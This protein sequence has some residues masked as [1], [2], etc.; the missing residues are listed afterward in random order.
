MWLTVIF[1]C[2]EV[3]VH[4]MFWCWQLSCVVVR[5]CRRGRCCFEHLITT[6]R[7]VE[8]LSVSSGVSAMPFDALE[9][10]LLPCLTQFWPRSDLHCSTLINKQSFIRSSAN[11]MCTSLLLRWFVCVCLFLFIFFML[12]L[13]ILYKSGNLDLNDCEGWMRWKLSDSCFDEHVFA[14]LC[15]MCV[16]MHAMEKLNAGS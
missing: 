1:V 3:T 7:T 15:V 16:T 4:D 12:G 9:L 14:T 11:I 10:V 13:L 6:V 2:S 5:G 8:S